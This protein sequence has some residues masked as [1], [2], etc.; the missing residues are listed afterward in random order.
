MVKTELDFCLL[1]KNQRY[2]NMVYLENRKTQS[3]NWKDLNTE[4]SITFKNEKFYISKKWN[5]INFNKQEF[6]K[7]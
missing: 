4:K 3:Q 1:S 6:H 7:Q 5:K 2:K